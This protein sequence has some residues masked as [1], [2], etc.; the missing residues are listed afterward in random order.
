MKK[1]NDIEYALKRL[2]RAVNGWIEAKNDNPL[3]LKSLTKLQDAEIELSSA[4][5]TAETVLENLIQ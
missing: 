2:V 4:L 3:T 1:Q 5:S